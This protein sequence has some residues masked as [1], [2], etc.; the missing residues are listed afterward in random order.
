MA[1]SSSELKKLQKLWY[2]KLKKSGFNDIE[3][4]E[5]N[6]KVWSADKFG[7]KKALVQ[8]G[9]WEAKEEYYR[10]SGW[11][12]N[13]YQFATKLERLIWEEHD[14]GIS[15][16]DITKMLKKRRVKTNRDKVWK[17]IK[18]LEDTMKSMYL[19]GNK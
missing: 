8:N 14:K 16:V 4:D 7:P 19:A 10:L 13:E 1:T 17:T 2:A 5:D 9:G 3:Q 18:R 11:F 6:L 15:I 12:L